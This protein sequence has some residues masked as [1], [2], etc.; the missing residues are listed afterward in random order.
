MSPV[1]TSSANTHATVAAP[2]KTAS[3]PSLSGPSSARIAATT[4]TAPGLL[5]L[6]RLPDGI[7]EPR[8]RLGGRDRPEQAEPGDRPTPTETSTSC[9]TGSRPHTIRTYAFGHY[10][11]VPPAGVDA[12]ARD[13]IDRV[14]DRRLPL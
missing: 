8:P 2:M 13:R 11:L 4:P 1:W 5:G 12:L 9:I 7:E 14:E 3:S 6:G 10:G